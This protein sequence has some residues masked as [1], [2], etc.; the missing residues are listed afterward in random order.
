MPTVKSVSV[1]DTFK[2]CRGV[3][4]GDILSPLLFNLFI[5]DVIPQFLESD[6]YPA[7]LIHKDVGCLLYADDLM[8]LST[9]PTGLQNSL[10]KLST[11]CKQWKLA[12]NL[13]KSKTMCFTKHGQNTKHQFMFGEESLEHVKS[14]SY[15]GIELSQTG[16]FKLAQKGMTDKAMK[17]LFK[18]K[19]LLHDSNLKPSVCL[20][21]FDQLIKPICLYGCEIWGPDYLKAII[22]SQETSGKFEES[23]E[24][25]MCEKLNI[26]FSKF[27][28]GVHK[29]DSN[30][31]VR[32]ELG[33]F[34]LGIDIVAT[35]LKHYQRLESRDDNSLLSQAFTLSK[36]EIHPDNKLW[37]SRCF[38]LQE[39]VKKYSGLDESSIYI[40]KLVK[41]SIS[42]NYSNYWESKIVT[43]PKMRTYVQ[44]KSK[45]GLE[46]Y[47]AINNEKHRKA[48]TRFRIS[49]HT[50]AIERGRYTTP[51]TPH[52]DRICKHCS[53]NKV[54]DE[55]HFLMAC[56]NYNPQ[57]KELLDRLDNLCLNFQSLNIKQQFIYMLSAGVD[58]ANHVSLFIFENIP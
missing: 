19:G 51:P 23:L 21:L 36:A 22:P 54:E 1:T 18:L 48:M 47:L 30:S 2:T 46:D 15:L 26:S 53:D 44:F 10:D 41:E 56:T 11:Y 20:K 52:T 9:S 28:L 33:T 38:Q 3:K 5:N 40:R 58:V 45:F 4:Q 7:T 50:L 8:I 16:S 42:S 25:F 14:Y 13:S 6:S 49:A 32:G 12:V 37:G 17:A 34:P 29:K 31:A 27:V 57:R 43:Q 39:F 35:V 55:F 24:K